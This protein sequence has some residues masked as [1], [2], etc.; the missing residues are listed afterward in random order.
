MDRT[1]ALRVG[2]RIL[3]INGV[4][5]R[6][7][8]VEEAVRLLPTN[9]DSI[10]IKVMRH[11]SLPPAGYTLPCLLLQYAMPVSCS[12][13]SSMVTVLFSTS[14]S[15]RIASKALM[16]LNI[17]SSHLSVRTCEQWQYG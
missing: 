9:D 5:L 3:A 17:R 12:D 15:V 1:G 6:G 7:R 11:L 13:G 8:C 10:N 16:L 14:L 2:D 4:A